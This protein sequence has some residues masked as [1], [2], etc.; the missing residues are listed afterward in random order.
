MAAKVTIMPSSRQQHSSESTPSTTTGIHQASHRSSSFASHSRSHRQANAE[1]TSKIPAA[2]HSPA[3][4]ARIARPTQI[5]PARSQP[6]PDEVSLLR[7]EFTD[8]YLTHQYG[9]FQGHQISSIT[10]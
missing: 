7:L 3:A 1:K 5:R 6:L 10:A 9:P 2:P 4:P 8:I